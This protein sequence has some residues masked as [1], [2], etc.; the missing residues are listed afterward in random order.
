MTRPSELPPSRRHPAPATIGNYA[1]DV[2]ELLKDEVRHDRNKTHCRCVPC[3]AE[4]LSQAGWRLSV[5][6]DGRGGGSGLTIVEASADSTQLHGDI[7]DELH[8]RLRVFYQSARMVHETYI[9]VRRH[10]NDNEQV[11]G[12]GHCVACE[13]F[14]N[15]RKH[16]R[17]RRVSGFCPACEIAWRR[18]RTRN[19]DGLRPDFIRHRKKETAA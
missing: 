14:C 2:G 1:I 19:P 12:L 15:P 3:E 7:E 6:G 9:E 10:G 16:P 11:G 13:H 8:K 17:D 5:M 18:W 4:R